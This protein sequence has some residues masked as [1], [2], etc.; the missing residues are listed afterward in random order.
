MATVLSG[1]VLGSAGS[2]ADSSD[3][4]IASVTVNGACNFAE[5]TTGYEKTL[6]LIGDT[7]TTETE[8]SRPSMSVTCNDPNG[9]AVYV[10]GASDE[11]GAEND[12]HVN[13]M[14]KEDKSAYI[15]TGTSGNGS[16]WAMK[17]TNAD[18]GTLQNGF[19]TGTY[20]EVPNAATEIVKVDGSSTGSQ[21][22]NMQMDYTVHVANNQA[23]GTYTG[24]VKYTIVH[25]GSN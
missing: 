21:T 17:V 22:L 11:M 9:F 8:S 20:H 6:T 4:A 10:V 18:T 2:Y 23:A 12:K 7:A 5:G 16:W 25:S 24:K 3:Q 13:Y 15:P 19:V 1:A 14:V